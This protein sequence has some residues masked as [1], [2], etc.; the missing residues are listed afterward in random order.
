M[1]LPVGEIVISEQKT[2]QI[3]G[4]KSYVG[5]WIQRRSN[6]SIHSGTERSKMT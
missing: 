6:G 3:Q 2:T 4:G 5:L 1:K